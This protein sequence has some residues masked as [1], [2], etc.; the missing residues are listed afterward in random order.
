MAG[1]LA[2]RIRKIR[3]DINAIFISGYTADVIDS[4]GLLQRVDFI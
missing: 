2:G 3:K 1:K 4:Q